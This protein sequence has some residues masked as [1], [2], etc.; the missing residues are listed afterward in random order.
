MVWK[1]IQ[2]SIL[3]PK[4]GKSNGREMWIL[5]TTPYRIFNDLHEVVSNPRSGYNG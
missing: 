1:A 5:G 2:Q 3:R 4:S